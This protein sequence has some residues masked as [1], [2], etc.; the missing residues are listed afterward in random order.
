MTEYD[1][2]D[3][4]PRFL[5]GPRAD[6][7]GWDPGEYEP[8]FDRIDD[9]SVGTHGA[10]PDSSYYGGLRPVSGVYSSAREYYLAMRDRARRNHAQYA[11]Y[12]RSKPS[13]TWMRSTRASSR[14]RSPAA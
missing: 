2:N 7:P 10:D 6:A 12:R 4:A 3:P 8:R 1:P 13:S 9:G 11:D 5:P 14:I